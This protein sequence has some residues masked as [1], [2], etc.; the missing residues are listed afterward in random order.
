MSRR[1]LLLLVLV[2][3][4]AGGG[5]WWWLHQGQEATDNAYIKAD[6]LPIMSRV[7]GTVT[8]ILVEDNQLVKAG[9]PLLKLDPSDYQIALAQAKASLAQQQAVLDHLIDRQQAQQTLVESARAS[10]DAATAELKRAQQQVDRLSRLSGKQ[11]VSQDDLDAAE[12]SRDAAKARLAQAKAQI[13]TE[14]AELTVILGEKPQ[15][16]ATVAAAQAQVDDAQLQL[17]YTTLLAPRDGMVTSRQVQL[18]QSASPG[19]R[20]LSL[21]TPRIWVE[22]NYKET[23]VAKMQVGQDVDV[24]ADALSGVHFK[25]HIESFAGA[26]GSEFALLPPQNATG[27]FTKV[28]QRLPVRVAFDA[29]QDLSVLRPGMSVLATV[30]TE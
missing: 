12:L 28:V 14:Q 1:I 21:V 8:D 19:S 30:H 16:E 10:S 3:L 7:N 6:I 20:L 11:Y 13:A 9:T 18:G 17:S 29:G 5:A 22:A 25:G 15:L 27:N 24:E 26:T 4:A 2:I 23:Q